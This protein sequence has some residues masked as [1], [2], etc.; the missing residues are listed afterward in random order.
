MKDFVSTSWH[1]FLM[2]VI[3]AIF[4]AIT[5]AIVMTIPVTNLVYSGEQE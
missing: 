3:L 2:Q 4:F 5:V 1:R